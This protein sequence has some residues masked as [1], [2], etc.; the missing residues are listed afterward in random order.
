MPFRPNPN[1]KLTIGDRTYRFAEHPA[2]PGMAYGQSGRRGTVYQLIDDAGDAWALKVFLRQFREPRLV[3]QAERI[4]TYTSLPGLK[5]CERQVLTGSQHASLLRNQS[6]LT[7]AVVMPWIHG[8]TWMEKVLAKEALTPDHSLRIARSLADVLLHMEERGLAHCD[9]SG[10]NVLLSPEGKVEFVDLE[11]MY[12]PELVRPKALPGGSPGYAHKTAPEG[13]WRDEADRFAGAVLLAE[14]LGWCDERVCGSSWGEGYFAPDEMGTNSRR[15]HLLQSVLSERWGE[16]LGEL[17][18]AAWYSDTLSKCPTFSEWL[19]A[20]PADVPDQMPPSDKEPI[21]SGS[22]AGILVMRAERLVREGAVDEALHVFRDVLA[23]AGEEL[24]EEI[25][26]RIDEL[27]K[28]IESGVDA[29]PTEEG[30]ICAECGRRVAAKHD[31]CPYCERGRRDVKEEGLYAAEEVEGIEERDPVAERPGGAG[32]SLEEVEDAPA[33]GAGG[34][35]GIASWVWVVIGALIIVGIVGLSGVFG[36]PEEFSMGSRMIS[37]VD[38][39]EMV[40]VPAGEFLMGS[41]G[42]DPYALDE[43][44]QREAY[45]DAYWI[46]RTEVT[47]AMFAEFLNAEGNQSEGG[48]TWLDAG[49]EDVRIKKTGSAWQAL[50]GYEDHPVVDVTWYGASAYCEWAGRRL[51]TEAEWEKAARGED[52]QIYPWGEG[53]DCDHAQYR[54]CD[55]TTVPVGSKLAGASPYGALDMA[56]NVWEW[57]ADWYKSDY[58]ENSPAKN[59][60]GPSSGTYHVVRGGSWYNGP[61]SV[62]AA[63][64]SR[65]APAISIGSVGFRCAGSP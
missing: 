54:A 27:S 49:G 57:V 52:G 63:D 35:K 16:Q 9:I 17:L 59:P 44:P 50:G 24:K 46:D 20:L 60:A 25:S 30:W 37:E 4:K 38:G 40:Y 31:T 48:E 55:G 5:A 28:R 10:P 51:P 3:G 22:S 14:M 7:Y 1:D 33:V 45:L 39:M 47:N 8:S 15:F 11:E 19:V 29:G 41:T 53:I 6:N 13:L 42:D 26:R 21:R 36:K 2:A 58:Y 62:R 61:D 64:R 65:H 18:E 32:K 56:G 23:S 34:V 43:F 12:G